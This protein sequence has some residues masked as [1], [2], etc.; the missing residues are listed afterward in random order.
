MSLGFYLKEKDDENSVRIELAGEVDILTCQEL[1]EM[2]YKIIDDHG[3][4]LVLD[5]SQLNYIDSTGLG[6]FVGVLKKV[7]LIDKEVRIV[8]LKE[9][10]KKLFVITSLDTLFNIE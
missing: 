9:S 1:K 2:L 5:C 3:K 8:N 10:T 6:V 4:D 7:K